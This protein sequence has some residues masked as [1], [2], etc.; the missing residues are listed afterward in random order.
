MLNSEEGADRIVSAVRAGR[1]FSGP[2]PTGAP[3]AVA[4]SFDSDHETPWLNAGDI[5]PGSLSEAEY[6]MRRGMPR[7]LSLLS[8][9]DIKATFFIPGLAAHLHPTDVERILSAGH[10]I[11]LH[12]WNH[13]RP[14]SLAQGEEE[15]LLN[16]S[17]SL[18]QNSFGVTPVGMRT[19]SLDTSSQTLDLAVQ[20]GLLYDSSLQADDDPYEV[21]LAERPSGLIEVPVDW[22]RDD[23]IYFLTDRES[24]LRPHLAP[25]EV[26]R[27]WM[28][29]M[30][31]ARDEGG[32]FQLTLHPD[33]IGHRSRVGILESVLETSM[34]FGAWCATHESVARHALENLRESPTPQ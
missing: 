2:W 17:I 9:F 13:E 15:R 5:R 31:L 27:L 24:G 8:E 23:A 1:S 6:G 10:E 25:D 7:I 19:P 29:E 3:C 21:L 16:R 33:I 32:L 30:S 34:T 26:T 12:G 18:F 28:R 20:V 14:S 11:G 22:S 4:L